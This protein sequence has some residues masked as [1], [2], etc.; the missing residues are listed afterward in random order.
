M[1]YR[2]NL[3]FAIQTLIKLRKMAVNLFSDTSLAAASNE[4]L[5]R[6]QPAVA[7]Y[8]MIQHPAFGKIWA[9]EVDGYGNSLM[10]DDANAPSLMSLPYLGSC[11]GN[12]PA[13][14]I[15]RAS[16]RERV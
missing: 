5:T 9:Y 4:I 13:Y 7:R 11:D 1:P 3:L 6:L 14:Q 15:G 16:C 12:D 10:M 8:G 2:N